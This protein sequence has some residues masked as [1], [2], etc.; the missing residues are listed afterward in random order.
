[1]NRFEYV[2]PKSVEEAV[3]LLGPDS[4][5]IGGGTDLTEMMKDDLI[6]P[7]RLVSLRRIPGLA[8]IKED[9]SALAIGATTTL[10]EIAESEVVNKRYAAL[11]QAAQAVASPQI[12]N[13][14]TLGGNL[15][16][17]P[18]CWYFREPTATRCYKRGGDYCYA[19][20]G[21]AAIQAT[22]DVAACF[23]VHPSDTAIALSALG[24][25]IVVAG[26]AG[27]RSVPV[28]DFFTG[29]EID[30]LRENV[31][32]P[33]E[34]VA[35]VRIPA[36]IA[37]Q[38]SVFLKAAPRRS[39]DFAR[40]SVAALAEGSQVLQRATIALG[41]VALTP[42]RASKAEEFLRGKRLVADTISQ[43]ADLSV[44]GA[45]PLARNKY[46]VLLARGLVRQALNRLAA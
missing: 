43:A 46:K 3:S 40:A 18:R 27:R 15:C 29:P 12:R 9:G 37:G 24:A 5:P 22:F 30:I 34:I 38:P 1:M 17:R 4:R 16:Q 33:N 23:A 41:G 14:S 8:Y 32:A 26:P 28:A 19:V 44:D 36:A 20:F 11:A 25:D 2:V 6:E 31:L 45:L 10:R 7:T 35:E 39:I 42:H 13:S 21:D